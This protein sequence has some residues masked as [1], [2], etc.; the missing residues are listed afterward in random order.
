M[1]QRA[2]VIGAG[3]AGIQAAL[4][5]ANSGYEVVL[6]EREPSIGGHMAQL[7]ETF[8]TLDCSQCIMTPRTVEVGHHDKI[9]L[10]S[11]SEVE[12][13][14]RQP[15][16]GQPEDYIARIRRK[17]AYVNWSVCTGCGV[18]QE[19]CP[20]K[21]E[22]AFERG[23]G[24]RKA[25]YT[26]SPQA[27]PNKPVI[28]AANCR[29]L[30][31]KRDIE[32]GIVPAVD[33][34]GNPAQPKCGACA[35]FCPTEAIEWDQAD[36][37][38]EERVGAVVIATG[39]DLYPQ[40]GLPEYGGGRLPD[41]LDGLAFERLL[42]ASGPT[43]GKV[44]R[45]SDGKPP[46]EVVFVQCSGSRD[47]ERGV[48]YCSKICCMYTAKQAILYKH[49]VPDGQAYVFYIDLRAGGKGYEEFL[50]RA[51]EE[52][53]VV[54]LRGKVSKIFGEDGKLIVKGVDTL[55]SRT[56]E[57]A[58]DLVVLATAVVPRLGSAQVAEMLGLEMDCAAGE[59]G[60]FFTATD[61]ELEPVTSRIP[62]VFLAGAALGPKDIPETVA[63]AS[64][65]AAKVLS[66]F[67]AYSNQQKTRDG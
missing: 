53:G 31:S 55:S 4:D 17:A 14:T 52:D 34:K 20:F 21:F 23:I 6:V 11:Y 12:A 8:P 2:L 50:N 13:L 26:L 7:S 19:K 44:L 16:D 15:A 45:P 40:A 18:C 47:P 56:V 49:R 62:G 63:Q 67:K 29:Y 46:K 1:I 38:F 5:I 37:V 57:V 43:A 60:G 25:I 42:A 10:Y 3:I 54:Y 48:P 41:V 24:K 66:L 51:Q 64:G 33:K 61:E 9:R 39:Y 58:A 35:K 28:D 32:A 36:Q 65:A 59:R 27:V 30:Q 22:S